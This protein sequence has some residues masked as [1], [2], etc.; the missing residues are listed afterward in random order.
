VGAV[1]VLG[2]LIWA[3]SASAGGGDLSQFAD[4]SAVLLIILMILLSVVP[5]LILAGIA[6]GLFQLYRVL[7]RGT[8]W[9]RDALAQVRKAVQVSSEKVTRPMIAVKSG[10]AGIRAIFRRKSKGDSQDD[11]RVNS[12]IQV[13]K[14][15]SHE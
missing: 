9:L 1:L 14:G 7:P 3:I 11:Q 5:L 6:Y 8:R 13:M 2:V 15:D 4:L 10:G 12:G